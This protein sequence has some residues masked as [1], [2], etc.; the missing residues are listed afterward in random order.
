MLHGF[1][2]GAPDLTPEQKLMRKRFYTT[3]EY[4]VDKFIYKGGRYLIEPIIDEL[5]PPKLGGIPLPENC[6][7]EGEKNFHDR[8]KRDTKRG[9]QYYGIP[10]WVPQ[11]YDGRMGLHG[12]YYWF[13][14]RR[15][16]AMCLAVGM[17]GLHIMLMM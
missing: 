17:M 14:M 8:S 2:K 9:D 16:Y 5:L 4:K 12:W 10:D 7:W 13:D 3:K 1:A 6:D 11:P 15:V